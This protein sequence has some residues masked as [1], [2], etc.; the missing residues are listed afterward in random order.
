MNA[1][2]AL[3]LVLVL[4]AATTLSTARA[5][6]HWA[7]SQHYSYELASGGEVQRA[8][9]LERSKLVDDVRP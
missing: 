2:L 8:A 9:F 6:H 7:A 5:L 4:G 1:L 3:T